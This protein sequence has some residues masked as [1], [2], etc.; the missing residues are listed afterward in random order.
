[1][2]TRHDFVSNSSSSSYIIDVG[3]LT[4]QEAAKLIADS[5]GDGVD[6]VG[7]NWLQPLLEDNVALTYVEICYHF[8]D[9]KY[10]NNIPAGLCIGKDKLSEYFDADGNVRADLDKL[11]TIEKFSWYKNNDGCTENDFAVYE[12]AG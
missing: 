2:K 3:K 1:M 12:S 7:D 5:I 9:S 10:S 8:K 4:H 6:E 11:K